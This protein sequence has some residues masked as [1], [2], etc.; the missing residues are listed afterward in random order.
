M[1]VMKMWKKYFLIG[2][3]S[4]S[5]VSLNISTRNCKIMNERTLSCRFDNGIVCWLI[6]YSL[7]YFLKLKKNDET[8]TK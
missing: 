8:F 1:E 2:N 4:R 7:D 6:V 5:G 3:V